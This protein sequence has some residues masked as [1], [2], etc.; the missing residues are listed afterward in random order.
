MITLPDLTIWEK[1]FEAFLQEQ[2]FHDS[3]HGLDHIKRVVLS[4]KRIG[5]SEHARPGVVVP[6]AWLHDC[7]AVEKNSPQRALASTLAAEKARTFLTEAD[8]PAHL[9][10]DICHAIQAHSFSAKIPPETIEAKVVQ[11]AD[12]LDALGAIG[13]A[14]CLMVGER[15]SLALYH[16]EDPFSEAR[17]PDD[18]QY[19]LD[20]FFVKLFTLPDTMQTEAGRQEAQRRARFLELYLEKLEEELP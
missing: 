15:L 11:D 3:S 20:H 13:L 10:D 1:R 18:K 9:L 7:V 2:G 8:Y 4:A 12:R 5:A 19:V 17:Q 14:R 6:A 16:E